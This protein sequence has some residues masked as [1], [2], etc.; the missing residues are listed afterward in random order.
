MA[1]MPECTGLG[2]GG[3]HCCYL[4]GV[5]CAHL[6]ENVG[7][8]RYACGLLVRYGSW[9]AMEASP[10][11]EH[12]GAYWQSR[13]LPYGYCRAFNPIFCC[14]PELR[15]GIRNHNEPRYIEQFGE[16]R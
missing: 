12:V 6:V 4:G 9:E 11:Y 10:E 13:G 2:E 7:G 8:R 14:R 15:G 5:R 3:D 16:V 1:E